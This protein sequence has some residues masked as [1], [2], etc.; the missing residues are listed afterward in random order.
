MYF[1]CTTCHAP[2]PQVT[3]QSLPS[4]E[5]SNNFQAIFN[6]CRVQKAAKA[7]STASAAGE[8]NTSEKAHKGLGQA[9]AWQG[10]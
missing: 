8:L 4:L 3:E 2:P 1:L 6:L 10:G 7:A 9:G 5:F